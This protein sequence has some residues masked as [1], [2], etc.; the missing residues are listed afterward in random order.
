MGN[1]GGQVVAVADRMHPVGVHGSMKWYWRGCRCVECRAANAAAAVRYRKRKAMGTVTPG[2]TVPS[3]P[4]HG[5]LVRMRGAGMVW[6]GMASLVGVDRRDLQR[7]VRNGPEGRITRRVEG[8]IF[9][10]EQRLSERPDLVYQDRHL[11]RQGPRV[12]WMIDCLQARG[13]TADWI[14]PQVGWNRALSSSVIPNEVVTV[15][16]WARVE[17]VFKA[18]HT[19]WGPSRLGAVRAWRS[20]KFPSDCYDSDLDA[21]VRYLP[22]PG[23]LHPDLVLEACSFGPKQATR[24]LPMVEEMRRRWGQWDAEPC[25][26]AV[27][28]GWQ[29]A[30]GHDPGPADGRLCR[31]ARHR[32][33]VLPSV[34]GE[35][36]PV[37]SPES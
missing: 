23:S 13:W 18:Y 24:R 6:D 30:M 34:W 29:V 26:A 37:F 36:L 28:R 22:V 4:A 8:L 7:I 5:V 17:G 21:P 15:D 3:G 27:L 19:E 33:A 12:R 35:N 16:L 9:A 32:H 11:F 25:A 2:Q 10:A 1:E 20:G 31:L 14:G